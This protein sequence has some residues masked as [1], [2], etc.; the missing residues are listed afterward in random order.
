MA[1]FKTYIGIDY[2]GAATPQTRSATIQAYLATEQHSAIRVAAPGA[3]KARSRNWNRAELAAWLREVLAGA[4][5]TS[6]QVASELVVGNQ[7]VIVGIDHAFGF[8]ASFYNRYRIRNWDA[9]L[10]R[11]IKHWP[12]IEPESTVQQ[13]RDGSKFC[14]QASEFRIADRW[15]AG[16]KSVFQFDVQGSVAKSTH[17]GLPFVRS[18]RRTF[19]EVHFWP[20]DGWQV[21]S[22]KSVV[23]ETW[24]SLFRNRYQRESRS[25]DQQDAFATC[26]WLQEMDQRGA[27]EAFF[28]PPLSIEDQCTAQLEG[29]I[30]GVY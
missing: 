20:F 24:P 28:Q 2:S 21:P 18:L 30:L 12:T 26:R 14:G 1:Q 23:S 19:P 29:W 11:F 7:P 10:D 27:L 9:F 6:D 22:G 17:A 16:A 15:A 5:L 25:V 3:T 8:P 4:P 13:F